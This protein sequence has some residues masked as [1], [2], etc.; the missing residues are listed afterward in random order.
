MGFFF[1]KKATKNIVGFFFKL[2]LPDSFF[3]GNN[4]FIQIWEVFFFL[5]LTPTF[6]LLTFAVY[7]A[8]SSHFGYQTFSFYIEN[9]MCYKHCE[10]SDQKSGSQKCFHNNNIKFTFFQMPSLSLKNVNIIGR[11]FMPIFSIEIARPY[12]NF[13]VVHRTTD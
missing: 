5:S 2:T 7:S 13:Q 1:N 3:G 8:I 9:P 4:L 10:D 6:L 11:T 12:T